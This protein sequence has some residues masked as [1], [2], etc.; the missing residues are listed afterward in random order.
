MH[1]PVHPWWFWLILS[2]PYLV[3]LS[4]WVAAN[5]FNITLKP[6]AP[7]LLAGYCVF[8]VPY[9]LLLDPVSGGHKVLRLVTSAGLWTCWLLPMWI[10]ARYSSEVLRAPGAK[11]YLPWNAAAFSIPTNMRIVVRNVD[12]VSPWYVEKLGLRKVVDAS[13]SGEPGSVAFKFKEDGKSVTLTTRGGIGTDATPILF[14]KK[15]G[16]VR[17]VLVARGVEVGT[18]EQDRQGV[19]YFEI[20]DPEGNVVEVVEER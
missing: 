14:T 2:A 16:R 10:K 4:V 5:S 17:D 13:R 8:A 18:V 3:W 11:W 9:F 1:F 15:I 6:L 20:H 12:S 19:H 7:W